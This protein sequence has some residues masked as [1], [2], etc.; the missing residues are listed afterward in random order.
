MRRMSRSRRMAVGLV[1]DL[2]LPVVVLIARLHHRH[3]LHRR[4]L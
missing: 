3:D 4:V 1:A 2:V